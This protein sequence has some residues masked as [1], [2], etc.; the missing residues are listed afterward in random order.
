MRKSF[1]RLSSVLVLLLLSIQLAF[2]AGP[3]LVTNGLSPKDNATNVV[4]QPVFTMTFAEDVFPGVGDIIG[5]YSTTGTEYKAIQLTGNV[6]NATG[7]TVTFSGKTVTIT[8]NNFTYAQGATYYVTVGANAIKNGAGASFEANAATAFGADLRW[9][10][11]IGDFSRPGIATNG[12]APADNRINVPVDTSFYITF[13]ENVQWVDQDPNTA[14]IQYTQKLEDFAIYTSTDGSIQEGGDLV[15]LTM[16]TLTWV[17]PNK[18]EINWFGV[19][20]TNLPELTDLYVRIKPDIIQDASGNKFAGINNNIS[21]NITTKDGVFAK[22]VITSE[23]DPLWSADEFYVDFAEKIYLVSTGAAV[24]NGLTTTLDNYIVVTDQAGTVVPCSLT[25]SLATTTPHIVLKPKAVL[26]GTSFKVTV[27][28]GVFK[29]GAGNINILSDKTFTAGDWVAPASVAGFPVATNQSGTT[30]DLLFKTTEACVVE[31]IVVAKNPAFDPTLGGVFGSSI[32]NEP[33]GNIDDADVAG[34]VNAEWWYRNGTKISL[35]N[36]TKPWGDATQQDVTIIKTGSISIPAG[37]FEVLERITGLTASHGTEFEVFYVMYDNSTTDEFQNYYTLGNTQRNV[38]G[39]GHLESNVFIIDVLMPNAWFDGDSAVVAPKV[40]GQVKLN[41]DHKDPVALGAPLVR[42]ARNGK[43]YINFNEAIRMANGSAITDPEPYLNVLEGATA[44][45]FSATL[46][47]T[48]KIITITPDSSWNSGATVTVSIDNSVFEDGA[49]NELVTNGIAA[50][51]YTQVYTVE[52]YLAP[53]VRYKPAT[54]TIGVDKSSVIE[55]VVSEHIY[56]PSWHI[57]AGGNLVPFTSTPTDAQYIGKFFKI[58]KGTTTGVTESSSTENYENYTFTISYNYGDSTKIIITPKAGEIYDSET[59][60]LFKLEE[61]IQDINRRTLESAVPGDLGALANFPANNTG[62]TTVPSPADNVTLV[63]KAEDSVPPTVSFFSLKQSTVPTP[64]T[65][66]DGLTNVA[67]N[68]TIGVFINEWV[69]LG[70]DGYV[71]F[72]ALA[73]SYTLDA[74]AMRRYF[75]VTD[76]LGNELKFDVV[77]IT[78][79]ADSMWFYIDPY[80]L[81]KY[82]AEDKSFEKNTAYRVCYISNVNEVDVTPENGAFVDDNGNLMVTVCS[83]FTTA[84]D[85]VTPGVTATY[86]PSGNSVSSSVNQIKITFS[87]ALDMNPPVVIPTISFG[88]D[89]GPYVNLVGAVTA[90]AYKE[91][92]YNT[93]ALAQTTTYRVTATD[94]SFNI[95]NGATWPPVAGV[96]DSSWTFT[97][98]DGTGPLLVTS[99]PLDESLG[100]AKTDTIRLT[101][102]EQV[103]LVSGKRFIIYE[104]NT[105]TA[106]AIDA[107]SCILSADKL[108]V[109]IAPSLFSSFLKY[110]TNYHVTIDPGFVQDMANNNYA[111]ILIQDLVAGDAAPDLISLSFQT[112]ANPPVT[113]AQFSPADNSVNLAAPVFIKLSEFVNA[114]NQIIYITDI[115]GVPSIVAQFNATTGLTPSAGNTVWTVN[116]NANFTPVWGHTYQVTMAAG[117]FRDLQGDNS[118]AVVA[119]APTS[120]SLG[121]WTFTYDDLTAPTVSSFWPANTAKHVPYNAYLYVDFTEALRLND[122]TAI[123]PDDNLISQNIRNFVTL[124]KNGVPLPVNNYT[125]EMVGPLKKI[126]RITPLDPAGYGYNPA[127]VQPTMETDAEYTLTILQTDGTYTLRD[128]A[129]NLL[130]PGTVGLTTTFRTEDITAPDLTITAVETPVSTDNK[131]TITYS[132]V[133]AGFGTRVFGVVL[134]SAA[135]APTVQQLLTNTV[136]GAIATLDKDTVVAGVGYTWEANLG[137]THTE[138]AA[139][140]VYMIAQDVEIDVWTNPAVWSTLFMS[141][142]PNETFDRIRDIM[143]SPNKMNV[144]RTFATPFTVCDNDKPVFA[145]SNPV[146]GFTAF[147][148]ANDVKVK[149]NDGIL[150]GSIN[151]NAITLRRFDNNIRVDAT[152]TFNADSS[153]TINPT[154]NLAQETKYYVEIDRYAVKDNSLCANNYAVEWVGKTNLWFQTVDGLAPRFDHTDPANNENCIAINDN[155]LRVY[156]IEN[157]ALAKATNTVADSNYV[158]LYRVLAGV[159]NAWEVIPFNS[160]TVTLGAFND[161]IKYVQIALSHSFMQD[162]Q[163]AVYI[164]AG[165]IADATGN[166][167][168]TAV[169]WRF[170]TIDDVAPI[171][172]WTLFEMNQYFNLSAPAEVGINSSWAAYRNGAAGATTNDASTNVALKVEFDESVVEIYTGTKTNGD[173][174]WL[175]LSTYSPSASIAAGYLIDNQLSAREILAQIT[176]TENGVPLVFD[177]VAP[178][179]T[180]L[181][182]SD[183]GANYVIVQF[184]KTVSGILTAAT[185]NNA[186]SVLDN[187][188]PHVFSDY[189]YFGSL[190]SERNYNVTLKANAFSDVVTCTNRVKNTSA[191][192]LV[193]INTRDDAAPALTNSAC[194]STCITST[195]EILL[196]FDKPV[197]K[198]SYDISWLDHESYTFDNLILNQADISATGD[199]KYIEFYR[200]S[201]GVLDTTY[202]AVKNV[203]VEPD[204][205]TIR[206][207]PN[208]PLV[209]DGNYT[210]VFNKWTVKE[211]IANDPNGTLFEGD[212]CRFKVYDYVAPV[213]ALAADSL[214]PADNAVDITTNRKEL[215]LKFNEKVQIGTGIAR[216]R[217]EN[218]SIFDEIPA[219]KLTRSTDKKV[220]TMPF[221]TQTKLEDF[222]LYYVEMPAGYITDTVACASYNDFPGFSA[223]LGSTGN[224]VSAGWNFKTS[225]GTPPELQ[226]SIAG[227]LTGLWPVPGNVNVPK[228]TN[229]VMTFDENIK[230]TANPNAGVVI[231]YNNGNAPIPGPGQAGDFGNAIEFIPWGSTKISISGSDIYNGFTTNV[232]NVN[233]DTEFNKLGIYYV[234]VKGDNVLDIANNKWS[235]S[236]VTLLNEVKDFEWYFTITNDVAPVL[237]ATN[238]TYDGI[239]APTTYVQLAANDHGYVVADLSMTFEDGSGNALNVA[240]GDN[241]R[242]VRIYEY[243]YN[244]ST[245]SWND[246]LWLEMPITDPSISFVDNVVTLNDVVLRDGIKGDSVYYVT[247]DPGAVLNGIPG[248][249]TFWGGIANGFRWRFQTASDDLF[250]AGYEIVSPNAIEDGD[251]AKNLTIDAAKNLVVKFNEGI[252]ALTL[253]AG[254]VK[255]YDADADT[256]VETVT[257]TAAMCSMDTLTVPLTK[258]F[259]ETNFYV[260][261]EAAA[262]GDTS[263][264]STPNP[265]FGGKTVW[266]FHTGDNTAPVPVSVMPEDM[267]DCVGSTIMLSLNFG[268]ETNGVVKNDGTIT[269]TDGA[270]FTVVKTEADITIAGKVVT[271][272]VAGLP[273]TTALTVTVSAGL[274]LDGDAHSPLANPVYTWSFTTGE[275]TVPTV[276]SI[277]PVMAVTADTVLTITFSEVVNAATLAGVVTVNGVEVDVTSVDGIVY[278]GDLVDLPSETTVNVVF[279]AG[280]FNDVNAGCVANDIALTTK[281]FQVADILAPTA[282]YF[283]FTAGDY[284]DIEL[285]IRFNEVVAKATGN[286][287]VYDAV[288]DTVVTTIPVASFVSTDGLTFTNTTNA[289]YFGS[290]YVLIDEG[291]FVDATAADVAKEFAGITADDVWTIDIV[292]NSFDQCV[293]IISPIDGTLN[294]P[295]ATQLV[296]EFC[297]ERI[298]PGAGDRYVTVAKQSNTTTTPRVELAVNASMISVVGGKYR[299]TIPIEGLEEMTTYSVIIAPGAVKDEA[300]NPYDGI[301]DANAW[302]FTTV[303]QTAPVVTVVAATVNNEDGSAQIT[304]NET[305]PVFLVHSTVPSNLAAITAAIADH[306]A[307]AGLVTTAN[308]NVTVSAVDLVAGTYRGVAFD[309]AGNI[310]ESANVVIVEDVPEPIVYPTYTIAQIQGSVAASPYAEDTV[311]TSG[312]VTGKDAS[313]FFIQDAKAA[314]SGI[315]VYNPALAATVS[316]GTGIKVTG[317]VTEY[318]DLTEITNV[319]A[320]E[321]VAPPVSSDGLAMTVA[322]ANVNAEMY[323]S[324][325]V[326]VENLKTT[327]LPDSFGEWLTEFDGSVVKIDN[328]LHVYDPTLHQRY[329]ITGVINY[330]FS[331]FKLAPRSDAD[332][333]FVDGIADLGIAIT[334]YPNPFRDHISIKVSSNVELTK[335]VITNIAGQLVKEVINPESTIATGDLRNG[336]Y[337]ISLHTENGIAKTERI[338]KR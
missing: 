14:G 104:S 205:K 187:G 263:T 294:V 283:P 92:V 266:T 204:M 122:G 72:D 256:L 298:V 269:I 237:V 253:P 55:V 258:L 82:P 207:T 32:S 59:W 124:S 27:N 38:S 19:T 330:T 267:D 47:A 144:V 79:N 313:G 310:G 291:T 86:T 37:N 259:D 174:V 314:W 116:A 198:S 40:L 284:K 311:V 255:V 110:S 227:A 114:Q 152:V 80:D 70:F 65:M 272:E 265:A 188:A 98:V 184:K 71:E 170:N 306:K 2:A 4:E 212:T 87:E 191:I 77:N 153:F 305:G 162:D 88:V 147:L 271:V 13:T 336:V 21:W 172:S 321:F 213:L 233:P 196:S 46:D 176:I 129:N 143:P 34:D 23:H 304:R 299:L 246:R 145:S 230:I 99:T 83:N 254:K 96:A 300:G 43:I 90:P 217:R 66:I 214:V 133:E 208:T 25:V 262:F 193:T 127:F 78:M 312:V 73:G 197:V 318:Y 168:A 113:F 118:I 150:A 229:L 166:K 154:F 42:L 261:V 157:N 270:G 63:F 148:V 155:I 67:I 278:T 235:A 106:T 125:V 121:N 323:E 308:V 329:H 249:Q 26:N 209:S 322:A 287:V 273:D 337:F 60:F 89:G 210:L 61:G 58:R 206:I 109:K 159:P 120:P 333:V 226:S 216:I 326:T 97:T 276:V 107:S 260:V 274:V 277:T 139:Y 338:I 95:W 203:V 69:K 12:L 108:T 54:G 15:S 334:V 93:G 281:T 219:S 175:P 327:A 6:T 195:G 115:T 328:Q 325:L 319:I 179:V 68:D 140:K 165:L 243:V 231:Y 158:F 290:F 303:D 335:A 189:T 199:G 279:A 190:N 224:Y 142:V 141:E 177:D 81:V 18:L 146:N 164:P 251:A 160:S 151:P 3:V 53:L 241:A 236:T 182:I 28:A 138:E 100:F 232:I 163:I 244:P 51:S 315:Y 41:K 215:V 194:E 285:I 171:A 320:S 201:N 309:A 1:T 137:A 103:K 50:A 126:L 183:V 131:V 136:P 156:F 307:V 10:F 292:D 9:S 264:V 112:G 302:N 245:F 297:T 293:N 222:T 218:G 101:F 102:N 296:L 94:G 84:T 30:I 161:T 202:V 186:T 240:R 192:N 248:S 181:K 16:P 149:F 5:L 238:P 135:T 295:L 85:V 250:V 173:Q 234:R 24:G 111:G 331:E 130:V 44:F 289:L 221:Q 134:P 178:I 169:R 64:L 223:Q 275:N 22:A 257:V 247:V 167:Y 74:N 35:R 36:S 252:E 317:K 220:I 17:A 62:N 301:I 105:T 286:I 288:E 52:N 239:G 324:V 211:F 200:V 7:G 332:V 33:Y 180:D 11:T 49:G 20:L 132:I 29:D 268:N 91:V 185:I 282:T 8:F 75:R 280:S 76:P 45:G 117:T 31:Y 119:G 123:I 228:N 48:K 128:S 57:L 242:K 39:L 225:D 316:V 56:L